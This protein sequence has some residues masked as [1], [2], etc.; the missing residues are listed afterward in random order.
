MMLKGC[1]MRIIT[2]LCMLC[3]VLLFAAD[4]HMEGKN[5][6]AVEILKTATYTQGDKIADSYKIQFDG[7][8]SIRGFCVEFFVLDL[9]ETFVKWNSGGAVENPLCLEQRDDDENIF[10]ISV[11]KQGTG[12]SKSA[13][14]IL[15]TL[16]LIRE[17]G[18]KAELSIRKLEIVDNDYKYKILIDNNIGGNHVAT[19]SS[20]K[21]QL[22]MEELL[23]P[24]ETRIKSIFPNPFNP[25][26]VIEFSI[27][28]T[29]H[30]NL[31]VYNAAGQHIST[32]VDTYLDANIYRTEW[33]G[34]NDNGDPI[35]S[36]VYFCILKTSD[37]ADSKKFVIL[38]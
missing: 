8:G 21:N 37:H 15:G 31:S 13:D 1:K 17:K 25:M 23:P 26:T 11:G 27:A 16:Q 33:S 7:F 30:V 12:R 35:A 9:S 6:I 38:R 4:A 29:N 5:E 19:D 28:S 36:G 10:R 24:A 20:E 18:K 22:D 32:L 14:R 2:L 3:A 34:T